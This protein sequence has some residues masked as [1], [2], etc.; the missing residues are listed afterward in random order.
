MKN[1]NILLALLF[2][3]LASTAQIWEENLLKT[4][5]TPTSVEK[6]EAFE[7]YRKTVPYSKG[8]GYNP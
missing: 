7:N 4:N 6:F 3:S 5:T 8:N 1:L 2:I